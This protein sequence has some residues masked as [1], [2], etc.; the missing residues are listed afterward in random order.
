MVVRKS[1]PS[2]SHAGCQDRESVRE[3]DGQGYMS[4]SLVAMCAQNT[5]C[6]VWYVSWHVT[7]MDPIL[8]I[9]R[10]EKCYRNG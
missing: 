4:P 3:T 7:W 1:R 6:S 10:T 2:I 9:H 8:M 5:A